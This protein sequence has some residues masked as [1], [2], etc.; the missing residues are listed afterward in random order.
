MILIRTDIYLV[1]DR[2]PLIFPI[3]A[4]DSN[5]KPQNTICMSAFKIFVRLELEK[6]FRFSV[7][8]YLT[9]HLK[10]GAK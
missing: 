5:F 10:F 6:I 1:A 4:L 8:H 2:K 7:K 3:S 9:D